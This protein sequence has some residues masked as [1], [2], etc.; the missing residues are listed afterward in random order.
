MG[1]TPSVGADTSRPPGIE[2][3]WYVEWTSPK[4]S[5]FVGGGNLSPR[6]VPGLSVSSIQLT[7]VTFR[8][9][10]I[11][12]YGWVPPIQRTLLKNPTAVALFSQPY[13]LPASPKGSFGSSGSCSYSTY[14]YQGGD[15]A[16]RQV[17]APYESGGWGQL[18]FTRPLRLVASWA[19][20][21]RSYCWRI[22]IQFNITIKL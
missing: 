15:V 12:P 19:A 7:F 3:E 18:P 10:N 22:L 17:A 16:G 8:A 21:I 5:E 14:R 6:R 4:V 9:A 11:R 13:G 1:S 2:I 20:D